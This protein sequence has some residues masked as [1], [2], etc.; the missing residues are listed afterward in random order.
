MI[1]PS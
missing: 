1:A